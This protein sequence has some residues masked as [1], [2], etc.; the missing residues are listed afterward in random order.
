MQN[1]IFALSSGALP[2]GVAIIRLSGPDSFSII[3][4]I[5]K[6]DV[7]IR[8]LV[9]QDISNPDTDDV[10]DRGLVVGFQGPNSFTGEDI[11]EI[12]CHGGRATVSSILDVLSRQE[13]C[14]IAEAGEFSRRAFE[15][16]KM[17][18]TELEG[19][20]DLIAAQT[21][22]QRKLA[23]TQSGGALRKLYD[24]W[25]S[26]LI[27]SRALIEAEFDFS[28]EDDVPGS[29]SDQVWVGV[30]TLKG[31]IEDHLNDRRQGEIVREGFRITLLGPP[32]V[33]KSSLLNALTK[34]DV[35]I[36]TPQAGTT[37]DTIEVSLNFEGML[38]VLTDTAGLRASDDLIENEGMR[39]ALNAA[40]EADLVLWLSGPE[41]IKSTNIPVDAQ[42][43]YTKSDLFDYKTNAGLLTVNTV[44]ADGLD[45]LLEFLRH[46][47]HSLK[48]TSDD[49]IVVTRQRHRTALEATLNHLTNSLDAHVDLEIRSEN[50]R[51][52]ADGIGRITGRIDVED[53]LDVIFSEFCVGK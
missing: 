2:S 46:Q 44:K 25:R 37:R 11:V 12:H 51:L 29:V 41:D 49:S 17:D 24:G 5:T 30:D 36:V 47:V 6:R 35:A 23:L 8:S 53:L 10:L 22:S 14:R 3:N 13:N 39:R 43:V 27:R 28:D 33:G 31:S 38:I 32:N 9:L 4:K 52:A 21:E 16:G 20:S 42:I 1:T 48:L 15:N 18:L 26:D 19:L 45:N 34:R 7:S 50:L 40:D